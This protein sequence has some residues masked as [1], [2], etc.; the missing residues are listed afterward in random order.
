[1]IR[2]ISI[3]VFLVSFCTIPPL[4]EAGI[5]S[6]AAKLSKIAQ[7]AQKAAAQSGKKVITGTIGFATDPMGFIIL[8]PNTRMLKAHRESIRDQI[9][10]ENEIKLKSNTTVFEK[11]N[12]N[13]AERLT[14]LQGEVVCIRSEALN[15]TE[16]PFGWINIQ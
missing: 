12:F 4:A 14:F 7:K 11:P 15:W 3:T 8:T 10:C 9:K 1:M 5:F 6:K 16:T 2:I 13:S